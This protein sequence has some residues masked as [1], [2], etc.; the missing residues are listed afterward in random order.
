MKTNCGLFLFEFKLLWILIN[1]TFD[2]G[3]HQIQIFRKYQ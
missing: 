2:E 3:D 1:F